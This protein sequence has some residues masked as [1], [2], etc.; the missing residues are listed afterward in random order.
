MVEDDTY[1][2]QI[3]A[4]SNLPV[5]SFF[6]I[7]CTTDFYY[8]KINKGGN[9]SFGITDIKTDMAKTMSDGFIV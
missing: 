7:I 6:T 3:P 2:C 8:I 1:Q 9:S 4:S 5:G